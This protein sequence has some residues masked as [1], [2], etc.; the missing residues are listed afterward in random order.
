[1]KDCGG[2][3]EG[4]IRF[5]EQTIPS[6]EVAAKSLALPL[7][8]FEREFQQESTR[9]SGNPV[10]KIFFPAMA[11]S[12]QSSVRAEVRCAQFLAALAVQLDGQTALKN[13]LDPIGGGRFEYSPFKGGF[14][15]RSQLKGQDDKPVSL[16]VGHRN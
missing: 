13:Y 14:E 12:R 9:Q 10:Y 4:V 1:M 15:L 7:A 6:Y 3:A 8:D 16:T 11:K 5:A 2:T